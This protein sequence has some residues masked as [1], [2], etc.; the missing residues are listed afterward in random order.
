MDHSFPLK[1][2]LDAGASSELL[3]LCH[4]PELSEW[5]EDQKVSGQMTID[6]RAFDFAVWAKIE[7]VLYYLAFIHTMGS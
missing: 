7:Q 2:L 5:V 4:H 3:K 6:G 1:G